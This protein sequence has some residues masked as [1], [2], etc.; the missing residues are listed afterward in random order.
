VTFVIDDTGVVR[1][2]D[3]AADALDPMGALGACSLLKK[4]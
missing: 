2:I 1:H 4:K 3:M